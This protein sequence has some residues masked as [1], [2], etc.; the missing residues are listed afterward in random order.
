MLEFLFFSLLYY[1]FCTRNSYLS[2]NGNSYF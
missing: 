2:W 1:R